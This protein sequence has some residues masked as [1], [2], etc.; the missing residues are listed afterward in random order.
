MIIKN[1]RVN[2]ENTKS[3]TFSFQGVKFNIEKTLFGNAHNLR[4]QMITK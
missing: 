1:T 3:F 2:Y 4:S